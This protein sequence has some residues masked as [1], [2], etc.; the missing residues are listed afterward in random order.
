MLQASKN[1]PRKPLPTDRPLIVELT[2]IKPVQSKFTDNA[3][4]PKTQLEWIYKIVDPPE[5]DSR[6]VMRRTSNILLVP[7]GNGKINSLW[8]WC[9]A[10]LGHAIVDGEQVDEQALI[11]K[12][13]AAWMNIV[14]TDAD[15]NQDGFQAIK[16]IQPATTATR[17]PADASRF[18]DRITFE[19]FEELDDMWNALGTNAE[20]RQRIL[21]STSFSVDDVMAKV[22]TEYDKLPPERKK[23]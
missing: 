7:N 10:H 11:G 23:G 5:L 12:H 13:Y 19:Q 21:D 18:E 16:S 9:S 20:K 2:E 1:Q 4:N 14:P 22:R 6:Q 3:G 8:E 17:H 15:G